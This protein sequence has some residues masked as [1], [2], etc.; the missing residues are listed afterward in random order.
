[1]GTLSRSCNTSRTPARLWR[2]PRSGKRHRANW[3]RFW[4]WT[5]TPT[6][7]PTSA[8]FSSPSA[9]TASDLHCKRP[10]PWNSPLPHRLRPPSP[11]RAT[12]DSPPTSARLTFS[13]PMNPQTFSL[14]W[15][16]RPLT[17]EVGRMARQADAACTVR[18]GDTMVL[19]TVVAS[20][21]ERPGMDYF[22]LM[23][24][25]EEKYFAAG[26]IKGSRFIKME[27]RPSDQAVLAGRM[28]DRTVRP[29]FDERM[30]RD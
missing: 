1:M 13:S 9:S 30:R 3:W 14:D 19:A 25:Y 16:G 27:G 2:W 11:T 24:D 29:L 21:D 26:K 28:I 7:P 8:R 6:S 18:Y 10:L 15:A 23:V 4:A 20:K 22:P 12:T 5:T 17:I